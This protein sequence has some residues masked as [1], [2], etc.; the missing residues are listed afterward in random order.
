[1]LRIKISAGLP[2]AMTIRAKYFAAEIS[3]S[4]HLGN[5]TVVE[6]AATTL[7]NSLLADRAPRRSLHRRY[8][9]HRSELRTRL[10]A[11]LEPVFHEG[12]PH[13]SSA[14]RRDRRTSARYAN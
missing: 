7:G 4:G 8:G 2:C 11:A 6:M 10:S 14:L 1:M 13:Q 12:S 3:R 5:V 9:R